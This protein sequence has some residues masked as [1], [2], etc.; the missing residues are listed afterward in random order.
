MNKTSNRCRATQVAVASI[1]RQT[2]AYTVPRAKLYRRVKY[3]VQTL[4]CTYSIHEIIK[5]YL[6]ENEIRN[7]VALKHSTESS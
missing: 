1:C 6:E 4:Q 3:N 7:L 5:I 2:L